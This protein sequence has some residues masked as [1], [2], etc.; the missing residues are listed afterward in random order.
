[1]SDDMKKF[2]LGQEVR[3]LIDAVITAQHKIYDLVDADE[4][5]PDIA[6]P[7]L[8]EIDAKLQDLYYE[9]DRRRNLTQVAV[10]PTQEQIAALRDK[11]DRLRERNVAA[12]SISGFVTEA[13]ALAGAIGSKPA[14]DRSSS[15]K[16]APPLAER[17]VT[18]PA[19]LTAA[20]AG[21]MLCYALIESRRKRD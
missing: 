8:D 9:A 7:M 21:A 20:A 6:E 2:R 19:L 16:T 12:A 18:I 5:Q 17:D 3:F 10:A 13:I 4:I 14:A 11:V 1:M 15:T